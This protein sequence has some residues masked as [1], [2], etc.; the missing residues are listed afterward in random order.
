[1][2]ASYQANPEDPAGL[3]GHGATSDVLRREAQLRA[4]LDT[5]VDGIITIDETGRVEG[6]NRAAE[7][8]FGYSAEEVLGRN[9]SMLMPE[10]IARHHDGYIATYLA[11][12]KAK[13]IGQGRTVDG[14]RKDG[15]QFPLDLAISEVA[16]ADRRLFTGIVRDSTERIRVESALQEERNFV[17]AI[18]ETVGALILILD[19]KGRIVRFNRSCERTTGYAFAEVRGRRFWELFLLPEEI[20]AVKAVFAELRAGQFP[21]QNENHWITKDGRKRLIS[22]SNTA[23]TGSDGSVD[24]VIA[25]GID[26]TDRRRAEEAIVSVSE[27]ERRVIG[28]ELHDALGQQLTGIA[29]LTKALEQKLGS[30]MLP[31]GGEAAQISAFANAAIEDAKRLAHGLYPTELE[32]HGLLS[33]LQELA[34]TQ[35]R[36]YRKTCTFAGSGEFPPFD[37]PTA[38]HLYRIAQEASNNAVRHGGG[39]H[40]AILLDRQG[41]TLRLRIVDDGSGFP[42][43]GPKKGGM[44]LTIMSY[45]A[46]AIGGRFDIAQR[47]EGGTMVTCAWPTP[48]ASS[49]K[50]SIHG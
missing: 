4:I 32:K 2:S 41:D 10:D 19:T 13:I 23:L 36:L 14:R 31:E 34:V 7:R 3:G 46:N 49:E 11:T 22:W 25:T 9:I 16:L 12:G 15:T 44:G 37:H 27:A 50:D 30:G 35:S 8:I 21:N 26:V 17:S 45:R 1:M 6:F 29:L 40:I 18:L 48:R 28:R 20:D 43:A 33:A 38:L 42:V 24:Y 39:E 47:P 5:T